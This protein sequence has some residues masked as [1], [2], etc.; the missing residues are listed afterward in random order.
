MTR[1]IAILGVGA[2]GS[3]IA[4]D[5]IEAGHDVTLIDPWPAH[6][7]AM[8]VDGLR[9]E[10]VEGQDLHVPARAYHITDVCTFDDQFDIVLMAMKAYDTTWACHFI[11]P[12]LSPTGILVGVQNG[13]MAETIAGIVGPSRTVGCVVELGSQLATPGIVQRNTAHEKSWFGLGSLDASAAGREEEI[14][15]LLRH[16]ARVEI[17]PDILSAKWMKLIVNAMILAPMAM[18]GLST[19]EASQVPGMRALMLRLGAEAL[20]AGEARGYRAVPIMGLGAEDILDRDAIPEVLM[21]ELSSVLR[22]G[23]SNTVL[24]DHLKGRKCE[25]QLINGLVAT[26][27]EGLGQAETVN[28][29]IADVSERIT[30]GE[31]DPAVTNLDLVQAMLAP[32]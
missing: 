30:R 31:I 12:Y 22:P 28:A 2:N 7:E 19:D 17:V 29:A 26:E 10:L 32:A 5:L 13:M 27:L 18:L 3:C 4:A 11:E 1:N 9:I 15:E 21:D 6:V 16:V 25:A 14:A 20:I 24:M 23:G 8:R